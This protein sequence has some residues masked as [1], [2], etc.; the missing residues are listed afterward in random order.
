MHYE[1]EFTFALIH[2]ADL[3]TCIRRAVPKVRQEYGEQDQRKISPYCTSFSVNFW[4]TE[5]PVHP[6][7]PPVER[8]TKQVDILLGN[9]QCRAVDGS[10]RGDGREELEATDTS[11]KGDWTTITME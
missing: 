9:D 1:F 10:E 8:R 2:L 3:S 5:N 6:S 4:I 7:Q 11:R